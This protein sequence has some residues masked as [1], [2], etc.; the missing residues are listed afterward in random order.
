MKKT[1]IIPETLVAD[2]SMCCNILSLTN[3]SKMD[4]KDAG[5]APEGVDAEVKDSKNIWD[6]EW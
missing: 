2:F 1:Y 3:E 4:L 5:L 6:E